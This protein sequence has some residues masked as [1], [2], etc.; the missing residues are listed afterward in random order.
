MYQWQRTR[1]KL[2]SLLGFHLEP[3]SW[4]GG[5][6]KNSLSRTKTT[7]TRKDKLNLV[8]LQSDLKI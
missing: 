5:C 6:D 3:L 2:E 4:F 1:R 7:A 8:D